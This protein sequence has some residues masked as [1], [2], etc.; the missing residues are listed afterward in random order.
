M[1]GGGMVFVIYIQNALFHAKKART[2]MSVML[3]G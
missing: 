2:V 1:C 3:R